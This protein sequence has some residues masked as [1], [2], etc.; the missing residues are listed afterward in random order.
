MRP[1]HIG[2]DVW[3]VCGPDAAAR[4]AM[5]SGRPSMPFTGMRQV[6]FTGSTGIGDR[7]PTWRDG[8]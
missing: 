8:R 5:L 1:A 2:A 3:R 4:P 6:S 7:L